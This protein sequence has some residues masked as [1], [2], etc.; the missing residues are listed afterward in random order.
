[1]APDDVPLV[2][3]ITFRIVARGRYASGEVK[4]AVVRAILSRQLPVI[5]DV[6]GTVGDC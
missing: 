1:M 5:G 2:K 3:C 6:D 4:A